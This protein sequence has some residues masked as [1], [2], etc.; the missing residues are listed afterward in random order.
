M[1]INWKL[2]IKLTVIG[3]ILFTYLSTFFHQEELA[4]TTMGEF[5]E[6]EAT[7]MNLDT[8]TYK[9]WPKAM[10]WWGFGL[11][12]VDSPFELIGYIPAYIFWFVFVWLSIAPNLLF[13]GAVSFVLSLICSIIYKLLPKKQLGK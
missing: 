11:P 8:Q 5:T 10:Y 2:I 12:K 7:R 13:W 9:G 3:A 1:K 4:V 6:E